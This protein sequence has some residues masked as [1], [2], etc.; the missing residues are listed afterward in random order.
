MQAD[1]QEMQ[2]LRQIFN[3]GDFMRGY[4]MGA[5]DAAVI[6]PQRVNHLGI[7]LGKIRSEERR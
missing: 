2:S 7:T 5:E 3:R 4:A 1:A 6:Y